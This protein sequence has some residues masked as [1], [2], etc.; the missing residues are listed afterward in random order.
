MDLQI[1]KIISSLSAVTLAAS[2]ISTA[3][4][5]IVVRGLE[6]MGRNPEQAPKLFP[7]IIVFVALIEA[8]TIYVLVT[9]L[10][11]LFAL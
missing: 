10:I 6:A 7:N 2:I 9:A 4:S 8:G 3:E 11:V 5:W 1:V